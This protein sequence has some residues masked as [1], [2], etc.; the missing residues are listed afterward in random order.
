MPDLYNTSHTL[1]LPRGKKDVR[2]DTINS[3]RAEVSEDIATL[4]NSLLNKDKKLSQLN[5]K[6]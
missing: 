2:I 5:N 6:P 1:G 4:E 3:I